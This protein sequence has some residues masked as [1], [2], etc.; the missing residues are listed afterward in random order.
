MWKHR[1]ER[2]IIK[3]TDIIGGNSNEKKFQWNVCSTNII[4]LRYFQDNRKKATIS[5]CFNFKLFL[6]G[7]LRNKK[8]KTK[9]DNLNDIWNRIMIFMEQIIDRWLSG[10]TTHHQIWQNH[11]FYYFCQLSSLTTL[12]KSS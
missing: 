5:R 3:T 4:T 2:T 8:Y 7:C 1:K 11:D 10:Y 6:Q 9:P 12:L